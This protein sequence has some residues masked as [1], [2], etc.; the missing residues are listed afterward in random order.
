MSTTARPKIPAHLGIAH[1]I[2]ELED[3]ASGDLLGVLDDG[4][5]FIDEARTQG[6]KVLVHCLQGISRSGAVLVAYI[7]KT[8]CLRYDAALELARK[9]R[10]IIDISPGFAAQLGMWEGMGYNVRDGNGVEKEVY[11]VWKE[12]RGKE[13]AEEEE[14]GSE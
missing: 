3:D 6:G 10:S 1:M 8:L 7:M 9:D 2:I 12:G 4:I 13:L 11:R 5:A 14:G